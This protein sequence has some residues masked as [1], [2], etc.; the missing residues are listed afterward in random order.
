VIWQWVQWVWNLRL[1]LGQR[2][3]GVEACSL[4]SMEWAPSLSA[5]AVELPIAADT[6]NETS[7]E[8]GPL[9]WAQPRGRAKGG[10]GA[11]ACTLR[12][13]G[14]LQCPAGR[15]LWLSE[16]RQESATTQRLISVARDQD[17]SSCTLRASCLS[18]SAS[19]KRGRRVSARRRRRAS[20]IA[21]IS[22]S[23]ARPSY[24][25]AGRCW[26]TAASRLDDTLAEPS[27]NHRTASSGSFKDQGGANPSRLSTAEIGDQA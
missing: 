7:E 3:E 9:E 27:R 15:L 12:D 22:C 20:T 4:R 8:Y 23:L 1:A 19:G 2:L 26:E 21:T 17:C 18:Q 24:A 5:A 14:L 25:L 13:D 6:A 16:T 10:F 11:E